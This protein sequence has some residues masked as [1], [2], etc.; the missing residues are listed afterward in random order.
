P[1]SGII[2]SRPAM[3]PSS[4]AK[5]TFNTRSTMVHSIPTIIDI[6]IRALKYFPATLLILAKY[7]M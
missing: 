1:R 7:M 6:N 3:K 4:I 5:S 2:L